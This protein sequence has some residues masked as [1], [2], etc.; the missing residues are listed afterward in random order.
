MPD[1][2]L[3][4]ILLSESDYQ[5]FQHTRDRIFALKCSE[6]ESLESYRLSVGERI[7]ILVN[8][9]VWEVENGGMNQVMFNSIGDYAEELRGH[10]RTLGATQAA[11]ALDQFSATIFEGAPIPS[12]RDTRA[13]L[14]LAWE[15]QD[16]SRAEA[17]FDSLAFDLGD[18]VSAAAVYI[19]AHR[20]L[21]V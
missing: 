5:L 10:L 19:R 20:E 14:V 9:L 4:P 15:E 1:A 2:E 13:K 11:D 16:E 17:F 7:V 21:F 3:D 18:I 8:E 6:G 12:A